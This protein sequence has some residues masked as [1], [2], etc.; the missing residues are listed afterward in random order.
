M[1]PAGANTDT[2]HWKSRLARAAL[3]ALLGALSFLLGWAIVLGLQSLDMD[4][5]WTTGGYVTTYGVSLGLLVAGLTYTG[6]LGFAI[7]RTGHVAWWRAVG[8]AVLAMPWFVFGYNAGVAVFDIS[9]GSRLPVPF[10]IWFVGLFTAGAWVTLAG[11]LSL[12]FLRSRVSVAWLFAA[13]VAFGVL[14]G[15]RPGADMGGLFDDMLY[16][17]A[18]WCAVY[19]AA[20]SLA[21]PRARRDGLQGAPYQP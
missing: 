14:A 12:T 21:L 3:W 7:H 9:G 13:S 5:L 4:V 6:G 11:V 8:F 19:A 17:V 18:A 2:K 15:G 10:L 20:F 1:R 16:V